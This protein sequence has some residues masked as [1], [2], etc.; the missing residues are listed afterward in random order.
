MPYDYIKRM[1]DFQP[2][3]G[4]RVRH[5]VTKRDGRIGREK[6]SHGHYVRVW[7]DGE[8]FASNC[9]PGELEYIDAAL[10]TSQRD[11]KWSEK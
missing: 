8:R 2:E 11:P 7:F 6:P 3:I 1:Y 5:T 10:T 4:R 9:H